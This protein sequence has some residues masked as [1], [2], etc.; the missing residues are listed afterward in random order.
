M[1][2]F[3]G[4]T[5]ECLNHYARTFNAF[6]GPLLLA[7][8]TGVVVGT[9][10]RWFHEGILP[11]GE[12]L[13]ALRS[14]LTLLDYQI[15]EF[16]ELPNL[17]QDFGMMLGLGVVSVQKA[18]T[19]LDYKNVNGVFNVVLRA[20]GLM[21]DRAFRLKRLVRDHQEQLEERRK[22]WMARINQALTPAR[23]GSG[24]A[25]SQPENFKGVAQ[26]PPMALEPLAAGDVRTLAEILRVICELD[27]L[28]QT[29]DDVWPCVTSC[30][31]V[32]RLELLAETLLERIQ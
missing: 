25:V 12:D 14:Y 9:V 28:L 32:Q 13:V 10:N 30:Y 2:V 29:G 18:Q 6:D 31:G 21:P 20:G 23:S 5:Q 17:T 19:E 11:G 27:E 1:A 7:E 26:A 16:S 4:N 3:R 22:E 15:E 8:F 24:E